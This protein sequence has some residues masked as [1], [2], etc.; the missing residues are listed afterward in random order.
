MRSGIAA[1]DLVDLLRLCFDNWKASE[2]P[3]EDREICYTWLAG[4]YEKKFETKLH[5]VFRHSCG[6]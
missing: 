4:Q 6:Y 1:P 3:P 5:R 2:R